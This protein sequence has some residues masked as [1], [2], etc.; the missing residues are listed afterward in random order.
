[1]RYPRAVA[2]LTFRRARTE[3]NKRQRA[4]ALV[5]AARSLALETGV[6]SVTLTAVAGRAGIHYSAVRRYFTSHKE[7]LLHLAAEG[8]V[9]WSDTVRASL[10]E[11][12]PMSQSRVAEALANGLAADP[13]FCDLLAN[14]HLHLEHEVDVER[15]VE[16]KRTSTTAALALADAIEQALPE[17]GRSGAFDI[18]LAAYSLAATLWQIANPPEK[19]T[20]AYAEEPEVLPPEWN[21]D[22]ASAL[23]RLLTATCSG[24]ISQSP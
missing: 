1:M 4:A 18:L 22:F 6:A 24:L 10:S 21:L 7:V 15:V 23:T 12:G 14:L 2:Q 9:R 5:E 13:L 20:D 16:V 17:L 8:W 19:L 3:E 11:P